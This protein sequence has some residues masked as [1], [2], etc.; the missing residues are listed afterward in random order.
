MII[1]FRFSNYRS[2]YDEMQLS[3]LATRLDTDA[4]IEV[5][6]SAE[7]GENVG[8]LPV[9]VVLGGERIRKVESHPRHWL[10]AEHR[11]R[12]YCSTT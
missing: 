12:L 9:T 4:A 3:T 11:A 8:V 6:V 1:G 10:Y 5:P 7:T 2:F